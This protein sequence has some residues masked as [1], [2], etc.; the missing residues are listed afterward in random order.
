MTHY[1]TP[2]EIRVMSFNIRYA[3][4]WDKENR[5][6][7]RKDFAG[8][9]VRNAAPDILGIQEAYRS[10]LDDLHT[11]A[12]GYGEVGEGREGGTEDEYAAIHYK[13]QRYDL[14]DSG[15][16]WL[17]ESPDKPSKSW[18][19]F[20]NRICSWAHLKDRIM[21]RSLYVYNTHLDHQSQE[22][23][24][25]GVQ[26]IMDHVKDRKSSD[27]VILMGDLNVTEEN[28]VIRYILGETTQGTSDKSLVDSFR[29][30]HPEEQVVGTYHGFEGNPDGKRIDYIFVSPD[31]LPLKATINRIHRD[32]R[33]PSDH[34]PIT[35]ILAYR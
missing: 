28:S 9:V 5:W 6:E 4:E 25:N 10:Q 26:L 19:S 29:N 24:E 30:L 7:M 27:P 17:S 33:Y 31:V 3:N 8:E 11:S 1:N 12:P 20:C 34:F 15:T 14:M 21:E 32:G 18:G 13:K 16:F 22:A 2:E 35:T 23:R